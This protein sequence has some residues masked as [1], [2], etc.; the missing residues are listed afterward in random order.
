AGPPASGALPRPVVAR[1]LHVAPP[2]PAT[3]Q[4]ADRPLPV[5]EGQ[6]ELLVREQRDD[7]ELQRRVRDREAPARRVACAAA[8]AG[9]VLNDVEPDPLQ[10]EALGRPVRVDQGTGAERIPRA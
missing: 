5:A 10:R 4:H 8:G 7:L 3:P 2:A 9:P 1:E 6:V